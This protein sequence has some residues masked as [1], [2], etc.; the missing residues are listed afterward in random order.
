M[1]ESF[2]CIGQFEFFKTFRKLD[3]C[4][5]W[6]ATRGGS[7]VIVT[8]RNKDVLISGGV[9]EIYEVQ[10]MNFQNSLNAEIQ[11]SKCVE[12]EL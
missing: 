5:S 8:T 11:I 9:D 1:Y 10:K 12:I 7:T 6:L 4:R 2:C 3:W